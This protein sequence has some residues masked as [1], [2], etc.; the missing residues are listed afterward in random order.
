MHSFG[1]VKFRLN[2]ESNVDIIMEIIVFE[3]LAFYNKSLLEPEYIPCKAA[4]GK[5]FRS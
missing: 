2:Y 5:R 4:A 3:R 1:F